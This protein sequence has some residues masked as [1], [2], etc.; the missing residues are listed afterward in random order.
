MHTN[1]VKCRSRGRIARQNSRN[2]ISC[3]I[4]NWNVI[5]ERVLVSLDSS[6]RGFDVSG[7]ERRLADDQRVQDDAE[8]P[9]VDFVRV[10]CSP[11]KHFRRNIVRC[12][13]NSSLLLTVK[14]EFGCQ[15][16]VSQLDLHLVI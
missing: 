6:V 10:A 9:D 13:A 11:L 14:V 15:A 12:T 4:G 7:L 5:W 16:K 2:Q 3:L 8:G 1:L